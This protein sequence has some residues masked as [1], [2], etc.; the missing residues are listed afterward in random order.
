[1]SDIDAVPGWYGKL[2]T[3]G[4]FASRRLGSDFIEPWDLWL[5]EGIAAQRAKLG[6]GWL[7]AYLQS[8]VWRFVLLPGALPS[9]TPQRPVAGVLMPSVDRVGRYFPLTIVAGLPRVPSSASEMESLLGWLHRLEDLA[10]DALNDDWS[11]DELE[12]ALD[13]LPAALPDGTSNLPEH[14]AEPFT[15][16]GQALQSDGRFIA[17]DGVRG[18]AELAT[19]WSASFADALPQT[20]VA[21]PGGETLW[22]AD[23][24]EAPRMLVARGL[25]ATDA[26]IEMLGAEGREAAAPTIF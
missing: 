25:P 10:L 26:F 22:L 15:A 5:G 4:D 6:E 16:M 23:N 12:Q 24:P 7:D 8:P 11:V 13:A 19:L 20:A 2:P 14:L 21:T 18:R 3:L 1:M 9:L 17:I